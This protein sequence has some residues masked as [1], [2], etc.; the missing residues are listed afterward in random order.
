MPPPARRADPQTG[1]GAP[2]YFDVV[3]ILEQAR[4][5]Q[6]LDPVGQIESE[7][8]RLEASRPHGPLRPPRPPRRDPRLRYARVRAPERTEQG[9]PIERLQLGV[10]FQLVRPF[11]EYFLR[12]DELLAHGLRRSR[13]AIV[14]HRR[15][16]HACPHASIAGADTKP[17]SVL[18]GP[19]LLAEPHHPHLAAIPV[20][21]RSKGVEV[22]IE[23][24]VIHEQPLDPAIPFPLAQCLT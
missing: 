24:E 16:R 21:V 11:V 23:M 14:K 19:D 6:P 18:V 8:R 1:R 15:A 22:T 4:A 3:P 12:R 17:L 5:G 2:S 7:V 10:R 9:R 20:A 13:P